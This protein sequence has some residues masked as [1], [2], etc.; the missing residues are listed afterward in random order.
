MTAE[1]ATLPPTPEEID[2]Q[3]LF[4]QNAQA[5]YRTAKETM[6]AGAKQLVAMVDAHGSR[7]AHAEQSIRLAGR[8]NVVTVTRGTT[9]RVHEPAVAE[10]EGYLGDLGGQIFTRLFAR[11]TTHRL[12]EGARDLL[13][14]L[15]LPR[16]TEEK[17]L[18]LFGR[19]VDIT[20]KAPAVKIDV[21]Q[22]EK[23]ARKPRGR[24]AAA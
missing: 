23:P 8:R 21:V 2:A 24:K 9:V 18:S 20:T 1:P 5:C 13:K 10:L 17:V 6:D 16:R 14:T 7:P 22:P 4:F 12:V 19:C 3:I 11:Q 15:S